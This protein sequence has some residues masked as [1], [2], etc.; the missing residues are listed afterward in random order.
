MHE[1]GALLD[2]LERLV[3]HEALESVQSTVQWEL[4]MAADADHYVHVL[5]YDYVVL[6]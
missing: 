2:L 3:V 1:D 6:P 5:S 4:P